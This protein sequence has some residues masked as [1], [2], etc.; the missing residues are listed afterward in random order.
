MKLHNIV[1]NQLNTLASQQNF[2]SLKV[3]IDAMKAN[4]H[5]QEIYN[6]RLMGYDGGYSPQERDGK[7]TRYDGRPL[8][9]KDF[10]YLFAELTGAEDT[11]D[12]GY[13]NFQVQGVA[14]FAISQNGEIVQYVEKVDLG[15]QGIFDPT[16]K[17]WE[18]SLW[19]G[20]IL[21]DD[22]RITISGT[23]NLILLLERIFGINHYGDKPSIVKGWLGDADGE[24]EII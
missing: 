20:D 2:E 5:I 21:A 1:L 24:F 19:D 18:L 14:D 15:V 3:A 22:D 16:E 6:F 12:T 17:E 23:E 8:E 7:L 4:G 10:K 11:D 9:E 13:L